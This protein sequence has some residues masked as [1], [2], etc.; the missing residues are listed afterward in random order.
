MSDEFDCAARLCDDQGMVSHE[1]VDEPH[2][3]DE[4]YLERLNR[5]RSYSG[6]PDAR[7][8]YTGEPFPCTGSAHLGGMHIQCSSPAH[9]SGGPLTVEAGEPFQALSFELIE[10]VPESEAGAG[11]DQRGH[12]G[13]SVVANGSTEEY[14]GRCRVLQAAIDRADSALRSS[15]YVG[16]PTEREAFRTASE[17]LGPLATQH[18]GVN[19]D[20]D[21]P[22]AKGDESDG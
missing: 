12:G 17:T 21:A 19:T 16:G 5:L 14:A 13:P 8:P 1:R 2:R 20:L 11:D 7:K 3:P 18:I 9:H 4:T 15:A 22:V 10:R 6:N